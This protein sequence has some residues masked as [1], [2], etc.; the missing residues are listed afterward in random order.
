M[1]KGHMSKADIN[2]EAFDEALLKKHDKKSKF[3]EVNWE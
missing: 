2:S 1:I 3:F